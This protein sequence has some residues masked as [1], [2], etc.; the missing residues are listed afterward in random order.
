MKSTSSVKGD[1]LSWGNGVEENLKQESILITGNSLTV[2]Y[3]A[4]IEE[5]Q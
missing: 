1:E 5:V 2:L 4:N 3:E